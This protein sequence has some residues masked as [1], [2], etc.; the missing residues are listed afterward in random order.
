[1]I[2]SFLLSF[3][4]IILCA[5]FLLYIFTK[6]K[7][8][9]LLAFILT[10][11]LIGPMVLGLVTNTEEIAILVEIGIAFLLFSVGL[12]TDL[13]EL[14]KI[15][16]GLILLPIANIIITLILFLLLKNLLAIDFVQALYFAFIVSFSST[17]LIAKT[18]LDSFKMDSLEGRLTI[19]ILL[20]EDLIAIL[21]IPI[22]KNVNTLTLGLV[23]GI[24][25]KA[26]LLVIIAIILNKVIY[27]RIIKSAYQS[28]Q[29]FFLLSMASCFLFILI[30]VVL[31]FPMAIGAFVG[32]LAI[33]IYPYNYEISSKISGIRNLLTT[34]V[35]VSLGMKLSFNFS[36]NLW[37][38]IVLISL[39]LII[40]PIIHFFF[41][42]FSGYG[43]KI[44]FEVSTYKAQISEFSLILAMQ[45]FSLLQ[46]TKG[47]YSAVI[48]A[49]SLSMLL[50]PYIINSQQKLYTKYYDNFKK[51]DKQK[52][53]TKQIDSINT[54]PRDIKDHLVIVGADVTSEAIIKLLGK[55]T[56]NPIVLVDLNPDKISCI[57]H[58]RISGIC[59]DINYP[60][61]FNAANIKNAKLAIITVS[62]FDTTARF[63]KNVKKTNS[64]LP[65]FARAHTR[66]E[67]YKLYELGAELV[68]IPKVL[69]SNYLLEKTYD[70]MLNQNT[71]STALRSKYLEYLKKEAAK[72]KETARKKES[73]FG[74]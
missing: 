8:P 39:V 36:D 59:G 18:L 38:L 34:I 27:P 26:A 56:N 43:S 10:G 52:K 60:D 17:M 4:I 25:G 55:E 71:K 72:N 15:K 6:L 45:G 57:T 51:L 48:I 73:K 41:V 3:G 53:F 49:T 14:K 42:L 35:F 69:E 28:D 67:A 21:A 29:S 44:A 66:K 33:S 22:L 20:V 64:G 54:A 12:G 2:Q 74:F 32:G 61:V 47:Q 1:M 5:T 46:L 16:L 62:E 37:L 58:D 50:T 19:G 30:S 11:I 13:D 70:F 7:Q 9:P 31:D 65:I 23:A 24:F 68:I 63:I 40:K